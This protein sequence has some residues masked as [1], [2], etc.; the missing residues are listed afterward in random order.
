[1]KGRKENQP[2]S[3][4]YHFL[5]PEF[6]TITVTTI[7]ANTSGPTGTKTP[8]KMS[9]ILSANTHMYTDEIIAM[10]IQQLDMIEAL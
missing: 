2:S 5:D 1:V 8:N 3:S 7:A 9:L 6:D 10:A 4:G